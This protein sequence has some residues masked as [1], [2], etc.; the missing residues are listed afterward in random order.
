MLIDT[1]AHL[2]DPRFAADLDAVL[3][4]ARAAGVS[5]IINIGCDLP[6]SRVVVNM[7]EKHRGLWAT[8]GVHPHEAAKAD[9][10]ALAELIELARHP[11]VVAI[12]ETGLDFYRNLSPPEAQERVFRSQIGVASQLGKPLVVHTREAADEVLAILADEVPPDLD[13]VMHCFSGSREF[14]DECLK[15]GYLLGIGGPVT[16]P[17]ADRLRSIVAEAPLEQL[18][19]ETDCPHLPPQPHRGQRNEPAY[20]RL[21]GERVAELRGMPLGELAAA[22]TA[23]AVRVFGLDCPA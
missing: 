4:R 18:L 5:Q 2:Q 11:R 8:V 17:K 23:N 10:Q 20:V 1:H 16:Y 13:V 3:Q 21:V 7:A 22:T 19:L 15:R 9:E 12:G 6:S 14:A